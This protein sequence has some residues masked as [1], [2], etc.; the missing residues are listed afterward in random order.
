MGKHRIPR[1]RRIASHLFLKLRLHGQKEDGMIF[2]HSLIRATQAHMLSPMGVIT[3]SHIKKR[4][5]VRAVQLDSM[6]SSVSFQVRRFID[7]VVLIPHITLDRFQ[8]L[9]LPLSSVV[10]HSSPAL[11]CEL[12]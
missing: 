6:K 12:L 8:I 9:K 11:R 4:R 1:K 2:I 10:E 3:R 7:D 5:P